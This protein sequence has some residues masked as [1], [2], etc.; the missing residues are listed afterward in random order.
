MFDYVSDGD[1]RMHL[2]AE[3][4]AYLLYGGSSRLA[5]LHAV[6]RD[7]HVLDLHVGGCLELRESLADCRSGGDDVLDDDDAVAVRELRADHV[8]A[9]A[10]ILDLLAVEA[11]RLVYAV[12]GVERAGG[13]SRERDALVSRS[14]E[15][16]E[17]LADIVLQ[18][19]GV[20]FAE[21]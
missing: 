20:V 9:L 14:E 1:N 11:I 4:G 12:L 17:I 19:L 8:S 10:V 18:A 21:L 2:Y 16:V 13:D 3:L 7:D 6:D 5:A 15:D